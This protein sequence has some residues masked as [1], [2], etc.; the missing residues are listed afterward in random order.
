MSNRPK[1]IFRVAKNKDNPYVMIDKRPL[2]NPS[3]S[4]K[5]KGV[6]AYLL[7]RPDDWEII[8]GDLIKRS[9][10]SSKPGK[11]VILKF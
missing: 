4:W 2:E 3:L 11:I 1:T 10:D 9:T 8:L 5:A 6:L 7:S